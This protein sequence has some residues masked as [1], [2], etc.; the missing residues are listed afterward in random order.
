MSIAI[1]TEGFGGQYMP[2][3]LTYSTLFVICTATPAY[4]AEGL[5][6]LSLEELM[7]VQI[8][9]SSLFKESELNSSSSVTVITEQDWR[10]RG[11]RTTI[12]ALSHSTNAMVLP[13]I[14]GFNFQVRGYASSLSSR[15]SATLIDGIPVNSMQFGTS[16]YSINNLQLGLLDSIEVVRGPGSALYGSDAFHSAVAYQTF[17]RTENMTD[18]SVE[19]G[20]DGFYQAN[21]RLSHSFN[22]Q[23]VINIALSASGQD[24]Q[25]LWQSYTNSLYPVPQARNYPSE[26]DD[27]ALLLKLHNGGS[28]A[29]WQYDLT[30]LE[31]QENHP[32]FS[33]FGTQQDT[34]LLQLNALNLSGQESNSSLY[35]V[36]LS[37]SIRNDLT[38]GMNF[39]YR[40]LDSTFYQNTIIPSYE[41]VLKNSFHLKEER[42]GGEFKISQDLNA[43][44]S[45]WALI[46]GRSEHQVTEYSRTLSDA[47]TQNPIHSATNVRHPEYSNQNINNIAFEGKTTFFNKKLSFTYGLRIDQYPVFG[48]QASPR[49]STIYHPS[50]S[51]SIKL[52]Y[53][54]A[55]RA[56]IVAEKTGL[57][58]ITG[59]P[60]LNPEEID[61]FE[62]VYMKEGKNWKAE[63]VYYHSQFDKG[64]AIV[65][66]NNALAYVNF[67]SQTANGFEASL[68]YLAE[69]W[70]FAI[71]A[72]LT[73]SE[74]KTAGHLQ[75]SAYPG[76]ISNIDVGYYFTEKTHL[77]LSTQILGDYCLGDQISSKVPVEKAD[78]YIRNDLQASHQLTSKFR[79]W[80]NIKNIFDSNNTYPSVWNAE[81]GIP[82]IGRLLS[83]GAQYSF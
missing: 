67:S 80:L 64:I 19:A 58:N 11:D 13:T 26:I 42:T 83:F 41:Q 34:S 81:G 69:N 76:W 52:I 33:G 77:S 9:S 6:N 36:N 15:G 44:N 40:E 17:T 50:S 70:S 61:S 73:N 47:L 54:N 51:S 3:K 18:I 55:F 48:N 82:D 66:T 31:N 38:I 27:K 56:P 79:L 32:S 37:R 39:Y 23:A 14:S 12:S 35:K 10:S 2:R 62:L 25:N 43:L 57:N 59:N 28:S 72:A 29:A 49:F 60:N 78:I 24:E 74:N 46:I 53:G 71:N 22:E 65:P 20:E 68:D 5:Y 7:N 45:Q 8:T 75:H 16:V 4:G 30:L 1:N 63:L 21:T